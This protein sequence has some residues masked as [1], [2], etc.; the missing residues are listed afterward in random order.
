MCVLIFRVSQNIRGSNITVNHQWFS[1]K[2]QNVLTLPFF[3]PKQSYS[4]HKRAVIKGAVQP[5]NC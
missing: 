4:I 1:H 3:L 2:S 5:K